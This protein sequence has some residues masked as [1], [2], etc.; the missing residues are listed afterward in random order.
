MTSRRSFVRK[1]IYLAVIAGFLLILNGLFRP[2]I[3]RAHV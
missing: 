3:G 2:E 1:V